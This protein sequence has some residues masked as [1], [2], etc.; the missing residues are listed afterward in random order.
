LILVWWALSALHGSALFYASLASAA[1]FILIT[2]LCL[3]N[4]N[5]RFW[6]FLGRR[7]APQ[8]RRERYRC[9]LKTAWLVWC[10]EGA[11]LLCFAP[12]LLL[13]KMSHEYETSL[14]MRDAQLR[15]WEAESRRR[16][17]MIRSIE[18]IPGVGGNPELRRRLLAAV[19]ISD[20][21]KPS[22]PLYYYGATTSRIRIFPVTEPAPCSPN[23]PVEIPSFTGGIPTSILAALELPTEDRLVGFDARRHSLEPARNLWRWTE[24]DEFLCLYSDADVLLA[25]SRLPAFDPFKARQGVVQASSGEEEQNAR[26]ITAL[27]AW[28]G[29]LAL[30]GVVTIW[31]RILRRRL[32]RFLNADWDPFVQSEAALVGEGPV[33]RERRGRVPV[34]AIPILVTALVLFLS[35]EELTTRLLAFLTSVTAGFETIRKQLASFGSSTD[36][37]KK[38]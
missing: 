29:L 23:G 20:P 12:T 19:G 15:L 5:G 9:V 34:Y 2:G 24:R 27:P 31:I 18:Q 7:L 30:V 17:A 32:L 37:T 36:E 35:E 16:G 8:I 11:L 38:S 21:K 13:F 33:P 3:R 1:V 25:R 4:R 14:R 22:S 26:T 10:V 6:R 28:L